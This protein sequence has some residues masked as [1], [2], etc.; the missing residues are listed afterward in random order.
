MSQNPKEMI[1]SV[2]F[3]GVVEGGRAMK[4]WIC[5]PKSGR[6]FMSVL[7]GSR[8][9][10]EFRSEARWM[11]FEVRAPVGGWAGYASV[12]CVTAKLW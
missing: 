11:L 9:F 2:S 1:N 3:S 10:W 5:V 8:L 6:R 12:G 7:F 4:D